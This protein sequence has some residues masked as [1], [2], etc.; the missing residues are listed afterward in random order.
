MRVLLLR[1]GRLR[2]EE[3]HVNRG[4]NKLKDD[5]TLLMGLKDEALTFKRFPP[6][7]KGALGRHRSALQS[8]NFG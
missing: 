7:D 5:G 3:L 4:T 1:R 6:G 2:W 8:Q